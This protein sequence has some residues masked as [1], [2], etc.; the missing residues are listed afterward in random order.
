MEVKL[1]AHGGNIYKYKR[2]NRCGGNGEFLDYSANINPLG[3]PESL[4]QM[5]I[6]RLD[7]I[8]YYPDPDCM[9][10]KENIS[11]YL[12]V[13]TNRIFTANGAAE[14]IFILFDVLR[15]RKVLIPAPTFS[16]Y[17]KAAE[18]A[19]VGV[20]YFERKEANGFNLDMEEFY[21]SAV[22]E[23]ADAVLL[24]NPNNPTSTLITRDD[25]EGFIDK[26]NKAGIDVIV[27]EAFIEL[28]EGVN[29]SIVD[30]VD[31]YDKLFIIR[32]FTKYF[33]MPGLRLGY[34]VGCTGIIEKMEEKKVP[35]SVNTFACHAGKLLHTESGYI[36]KTAAWLK[37]EKEWLYEQ[38]REID[39][40]K[41]FYPKTNFMLV[42]IL[43][44]GLEAGELRNRLL[45]KG[46]LI[47]HAGN[48]KFLDNRFFRVAVK[49]RDSNIKFMKAIKEVAKEA[50]GWEK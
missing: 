40:F 36:K 42:K 19:G 12:G 8:V 31:S 48:F 9:E 50:A 44:E 22:E 28:T 41:V 4:K 35:W 15:P 3:V 34:G 2:N 38:L 23:G 14:V 18:I 20:I 37:E 43:V 5:I 39:I 46:I 13:D 7:E 29:N 47:R 24:C 26:C 1:D 10:L 6:S 21:G 16:E 17:G 32:A 11:K 27:D 30:L 25:M 49:D 45:E 33:A